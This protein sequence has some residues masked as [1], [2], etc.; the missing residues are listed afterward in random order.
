MRQRFVSS[1][2]LAPTP[3]LTF[4]FTFPSLF[5]LL[6]LEILVDEDSLLSPSSRI[7]AKTLVAPALVSYI[8]CVVL[9][10][11]PVVCLARALSVE[12][13]FLSL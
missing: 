13:A 10:L 7:F 8:H 6:L 1:S 5:R 11:T 3:A 2:L 12:T 4:K 9:E